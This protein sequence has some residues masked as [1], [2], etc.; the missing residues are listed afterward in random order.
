MK[1]LSGTKATI[2]TTEQLNVGGPEGKEVGSVH[3]LAFDSRTPP[4]TNPTTTPPNNK[5]KDGRRVKNTSCLKLLAGEDDALLVWRDSLL[6]TGSC[7]HGR[8]MEGRPPKMLGGLKCAHAHCGGVA[9][10]QMFDSWFVFWAPPVR[11]MI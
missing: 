5:K 11:G 6:D 8:C 9:Y 4:Q 10:S 3:L 1:P 2:G 7:E